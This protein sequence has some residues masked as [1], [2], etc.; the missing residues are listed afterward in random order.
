MLMMDGKGRIGMQVKD[1]GIGRAG[2]D[3]GILELG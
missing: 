3:D 2:S 1:G